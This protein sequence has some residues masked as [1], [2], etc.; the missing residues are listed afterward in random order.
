MKGRFQILLK[1]LDRPNSIT[2]QKVQMNLNITPCSS[3]DLETLQTIAYETFNDT[4]RDLNT[5][6]T[7][8][9]YLQKAFT[10]QKLFSELNNKD[11]QFYFLYVENEPAGYLKINSAPVQSDTNETESIEVER[12]YI[13]KAFQ[14]K[15]FGKIL[16]NH[17]FHV[18]RE[19][20]KT[21]VW[22]SCWEKNT[23]AI[24]F[25]TRM[26]FNKAG[27]QHFKIGNELQD[28]FIMRKET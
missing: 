28:D 2:T 24:A 15:G 7:I 10:K 18:A 8:D 11:S 16:M 4:Y 5:Q 1:K 12:F 21:S 25:Y 22:L 20:N 23:D 9:R 3:T 13:R 17:A 26:G 14:G 19:M 27:R 6:E